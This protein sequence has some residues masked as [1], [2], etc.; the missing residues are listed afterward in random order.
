MSVTGKQL[1]ARDKHYIILSGLFAYLLVNFVTAITGVEASFY[2]L[3]NVPPDADEN[4]IRLAFR[5][6]AR[7]NHPDRVGASGADMFMAVRHGYESLMDPNK[8]WAYDRFGTGIMR[9][10]KCQTQLDFLHEGLINSAG[11]HLTTLSV[12]LG[13]TL[14]GGRSWVTLVSAH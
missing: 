6:F 2:E 7:K 13:S 14:L 11:F 10:T 8:R 5:S 9:C 3:L 1:T 4:T 12:I